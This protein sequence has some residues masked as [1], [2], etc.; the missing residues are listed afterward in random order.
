MNNFQKLFLQV[1]IPILFIQMFLSEN[2][3]SAP[4]KTGDA[5]LIHHLRLLGDGTIGLYSENNEDA[6][7]S[8]GI[9]DRGYLNSY[10]KSIEADKNF[11]TKASLESL[12]S[13][14]DSRINSLSSQYSTLSNETISAVKKIPET[15]LSN[16]EV[17]KILNAFVD[18]LFEKKRL[19]LE[20]QILKKYNL[21]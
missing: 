2:A 21:Q 18:K 13:S 7:L 17:S 19:E 14:M 8:I 12:R 20:Q 1:T 5:F 16:E 6:G 11:A 9:V 10:Y 15:L 3:L 4:I